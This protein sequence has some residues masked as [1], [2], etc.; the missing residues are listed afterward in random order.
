M[1]HFDNFTEKELYKLNIHELRDSARDLG[2]SSPTTKSKSELIA[3]MLEIVY[4]VA[5]VKNEKSQAGRPAR[6][7]SKPSQLLF[8]IGN[9]DTEVNEDENAFV[10]KYENNPS[11]IFGSKKN[12]N[13]NF[14]GAVFDVFSSKVASPSSGFIVCAP[15]DNIEDMSENIRKESEKKETINKNGLSWVSSHAIRGVGYN[16]FIEQNGNLYDIPERFVKLYNIH[17]GDLLEGWINKE[18]NKIV[19]IDAINGNVI[20]L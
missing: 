12:E 5:P 20:V 9:S 3:K 8:E 13:F 19:S 10:K 14:S 16:F 4:G 2:V 7:K 1:I 18:L 17:E 11:D 6:K 15:K